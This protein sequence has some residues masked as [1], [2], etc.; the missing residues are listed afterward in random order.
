MAALYRTRALGILSIGFKAHVACCSGAKAKHSLPGKE[1]QLRWCRVQVRG[2]EEDARKKQPTGY[3][4]DECVYT[5]KKGGIDVV[6]RGQSP[7][8]DFTSGWQA[9]L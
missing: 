3:M 7:D 9:M 2:I 4:N 6:G 5:D 1:R 8:M